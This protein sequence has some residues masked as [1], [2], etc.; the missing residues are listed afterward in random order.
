MPLDAFPACTPLPSTFSSLVWD[1]WA[2]SSVLDSLVV[3]RSFWRRSSLFW[4]FFTSWWELSSSPERLLFSSSSSDTFFLRSWTWSPLL[5]SWSFC[6]FNCWKSEYFVY[7]GSCDTIIVTVNEPFDLSL[8]A[9]G[10]TSA[11]HQSCCL[12]LN[13]LLYTW[14]N[15]LQ[16]H[17]KTQ[18]CCKIL[19]VHALWQLIH[20]LFI[21][22]KSWHRITSPNR[23]I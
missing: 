19:D 2:L 16:H 12:L 23:V 6:A 13:Q 22:L 18:I 8:Q 7:R 1:S 20:K 9:G 14:L 5:S 3:L 10:Q 11:L 15:E 17:I 4:S 21:L